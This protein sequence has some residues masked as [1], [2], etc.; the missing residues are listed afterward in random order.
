MIALKVLSTAYLFSHTCFIE[1][2]IKIVSLLWWVLA[3]LIANPSPKNSLLLSRSLAREALAKYI[4][5]STK[6]LIRFMLWKKCLKQCIFILTQNFNQ[7]QCSIC[8]EREKAT[9][10]TEA[11]LF[12]KHDLRIS[13]QDESVSDHGLYAWWRFKVPNRK[14]LKISWKCGQVLCVLH[15]F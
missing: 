14:A 7:E 4:K 9:M 6:K 1:K 10:L 15:H 3:R 12:S 8:Y 13:R 5:F 11:S 2:N